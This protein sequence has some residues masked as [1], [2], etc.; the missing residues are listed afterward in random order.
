MKKIIN[1]KV[2]VIFLE[3]VLIF[4]ATLFSNLIIKNKGSVQLQ[5]NNKPVSSQGINLVIYTSDQRKP[6]VENVTDDFLASPLGNGVDSVS[7]LS[8]GTSVDQQLTFLKT[9]MQGGTATATIIDLD[10]TWTALFAESLSR[11]GSVA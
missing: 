5:E 6:G 7:V 3:I 8:S 4:S 9:L 10:V 1:P 11:V 2:F